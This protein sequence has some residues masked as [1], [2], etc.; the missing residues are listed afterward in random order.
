MSTKPRMERERPFLP[1]GGG[2][3]PVQN[4]PTAPGPAA[5]ASLESGQYQLLPGAPLVG[6]HPSRNTHSPFPPSGSSRTS[7]TPSLCQICALSLPRVDSTKTEVRPWL[8]VRARRLDQREPLTVGAGQLR[9]P[10][11]L[12]ASG[13]PIT[14]I[15]PASSLSSLQALGRAASLPLHAR[16]CSPGSPEDRSLVTVLTALACGGVSSRPEHLKH[17]RLPLMCLPPVIPDDALNLP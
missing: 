17:S 16:C 7:Q 8:G 10:R 5:P 3:G 15:P 6:P 2:A 14:G 1:V 4:M 11:G 9:S 12:L 13:P